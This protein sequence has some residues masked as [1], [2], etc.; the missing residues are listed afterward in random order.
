[1]PNSSTAAKWSVVCL[2]ILFLI[3]SSALCRAEFMRLTGGFDGVAKTGAWTPITVELSNPQTAPIEGTLEVEQGDWSIPVCSANVNLPANSTK[4]YHIYARLREYGDVRVTLRSGDRV[5]AAGKVTLNFAGEADRTVV[6]VGPRTSALSF[7]NREQLV[8]KKAVGGPVPGPGPGPSTIYAGSIPAAELPDRPAAY[9]GVDVLVISHLAVSSTNPRALSAIGMWVASGGTLVVSTGPDYRAYQNQFFDDLLPVRI[10]GAGQINSWSSLVHLGQGPFPAASMAVA[11][12]TP[13]PGI[14]STVYIESRIPVYVERAYGAGRVVFLAFDH[15]SSPFKD[16]NGQVPFWKGIVSSDTEGPLVSTQG[17]EFFRRERYG[18]YYNQG[19][20]QKNDLVSIVEQNPSI[21]MP[22]FSAI[23]LFLL[24]YILVLV[25]LN[26]FVLHRLRRRELAWITT[27]AI[28]CIFTIGAYGIGYTMKGGRLQLNEATFIQGSSGARYASAVTEAAIFSPA[29]R[30]YDVTLSDP[31]ALGQVLGSADD[32]Q[33]P[34]A[35]IAEELTINGL[36]IAMWS[37]KTLE[38]SSGV[39]LGGPLETNL[40]IQGNVLSGT[41]RNNTGIDLTDCVL[42]WGNC[43]TS[44]DALRRGGTAT[45]SL[46]RSSGKSAFGAVLSGEEAGLKERYLEFV[47]TTVSDSNRPVLL[48][49]SR[50]RRLFDINGSPRTESYSYLV[51]DLGRG[52]AATG[53]GTSA[54]NH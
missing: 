1:M 20:Q 42:N 18:S 15:T 40:K 27:P 51:F 52:T 36:R 46:G 22:P 49:K 21:K 34:T 53:G 32:K 35:R 14:A 9:E 8:S 37:S 19:Q 44:V 45:V 33:F 38:S 16:W 43:S 13:K 11:T 31:F 7:L 17:G 2:T 10:T 39:D 25:P 23:A 24:A 26:Y 47:R 5:L 4:L 6:S 3:A 12:S 50:D 30:R 29:S 48:A 41:I 28:V 54:P